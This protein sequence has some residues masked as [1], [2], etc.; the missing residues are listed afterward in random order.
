LSQPD[1]TIQTAAEF[2]TGNYITEIT[3]VDRGTMVHR[4]GPVAPCIVCWAKLS[5]L[6]SKPRQTNFVEI[7]RESVLS[8][9]DPV[10]TLPTVL[11]GGVVWCMD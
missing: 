4:G 1:K 9:S 5:R 8:E 6:G 3:E 11:T 10:W 7:D 2:A